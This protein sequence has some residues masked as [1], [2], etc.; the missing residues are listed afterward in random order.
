M[1]NVQEQ[2]MERHNI[3]PSLP[4]REKTIESPQSEHPAPVV[5]LSSIDSADEPKI[6]VREDSITIPKDVIGAEKEEKPEA[7]QPSSNSGE[8]KCKPGSVG[9]HEDNNKQSCPSSSLLQST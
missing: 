5:I 2:A 6:H 3:S 7:H 8:L 9:K 4:K 1:K